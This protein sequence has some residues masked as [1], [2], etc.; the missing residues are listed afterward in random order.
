MLPG[1]CPSCGLKAELEVFAAQADIRAALAAALLLPAPLGRRAL[2]YLRLF[3]PAHK[4]LAVAKAGRL[5]ADLQ[6]AVASGQV[7]RHGIDRAAPQALWEAALDGMAERPPENLPL[8]DHAYLFQTV[9][10]LA[11]KAAARQEQASEDRRRRPATPAPPV[12]AA[13]AS[14]ALD[15]AQVAEA[16]RRAF[17]AQRPRVA[18]PEAFRGLLKTLTGVGALAPLAVPET[19]HDPAPLHAPQARPPEQPGEDSHRQESPGPG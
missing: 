13:P 15:L 5:L 14:P 16:S 17:D 7:R 9:W 4:A 11:E 3:T 19:P 1:V 18:P 6:A 10:N 8:R 12:A 2:A